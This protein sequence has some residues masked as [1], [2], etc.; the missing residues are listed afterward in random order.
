MQCLRSAGFL[1]NMQNKS[2]FL[3]LCQSRCVVFCWW[4]WGLFGC[5]FFFFIFCFSSYQKNLIYAPFTD[6]Q[7]FYCPGQASNRSLKSDGKTPGIIQEIF[8]WSMERKSNYSWRSSFVV[9]QL[10]PC[11][12]KFWRSIMGYSKPEFPLLSIPRLQK[13]CFLFFLLF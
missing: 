4:W 12:A 7:S 9:R 1:V 3:L 13:Q 11:F 6:A 5:L 2:D 10:I 8:P